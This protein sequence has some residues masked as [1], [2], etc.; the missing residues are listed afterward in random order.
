MLSLKHA[1]VEK[2]K[3]ARRNKWFNQKIIL[4]NQ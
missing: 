3:N 1:L 2:S 4:Y